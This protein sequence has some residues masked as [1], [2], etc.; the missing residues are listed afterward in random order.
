M[1]FLFVVS[2]FYA[3]HNVNAAITVLESNEQRLSFLFESGHNSISTHKNGNEMFSYISFQESNAEITDSNGIILPVL[4]LHFGVPQQG[5]ATVQFISQTTRRIHLHAPLPV[6]KEN[7]DHYRHITPHS[8]NPWIST[9]EYKH[10]STMRTGHLYL[11]PF[12]YNPS[13]RTITVLLK[14]TCTITFPQ[15]KIKVTSSEQYRGDFAAMLKDMVL[16]YKVAKRWQKPGRPTSGRYKTASI[17]P[18]NEKMLQFTI[19]DGNEGINEATTNENGIIK[20]TPET[21]TSFFGS[22]IL[23]N[24]ISL[25]GSQREELSD[26]VPSVSTIPDGACE[27]PLLRIDRNSNGIFDT[28]D[29]ILAYVTGISDWYYDTV[30][31]DFAFRLN[32]IENNRTYWLRSKG[33]LKT[34]P[35]FHC[36]GIPVDTITVF[37]NR[38]R[39]KKSVELKHE[40][41][42][43][44]KEWRWILL[45]DK[46]HA[47]NLMLELPDVHKG[48]HGFLQVN[49]GTI[50]PSCYTIT[51]GNTVLSDSGSWKVVNNWDNTKATISLCKLS[52]LEITHLDIRYRQSLDMHGKKMMRMYS[53][54]EPKSNIVMYRLKNLPSEKTY[55]FRI[56]S[57]ESRIQIIDIVSGEGTF[58]WV[59]T[60][61]IGMQYI[62]S[63][64]SGLLTINDMKGYYP[65]SP[66]PYVITDLRNTGNKSD[67]LIITDITLKAE[68]VRLAKHK[69]SI[70]TFL[71]PNVVVTDDIYREFSGGNHDPGAIRN[72]L[73]FTKNF[74]T[75]VYTGGTAGP[76][77]V[78]LSGN[79]HYDYKGYSSQEPVIIPTAQIN[80][81]G[82]R[83]CV[84][85]FFSCVTSGECISHS[86]AAPDLF[87][88]RFPVTTVTEAATVIDK[89]VETEGL[90]ADRGPWRNSILLVSDDDMQGNKYD[91]ITHYKGNEDI[92]TSIMQTR[93]YSDIRKVYLFEYPQNELFIKPE[94]S[95]AL[96]NEIN[97]GVSCVNFFGHG[98]EM[99]WADEGILNTSTVSNLTNTKRY[100]VITSFS[101]N[102]GHFDIPGTPCLAGTLLKTSRAGAIAG[103]ASS[104]T[105]SAGQNTSMGKTFYKHLFNTDTYRTLG[106]AYCLTKATD[107]LKR[108]VFLG[109]PSIRFLPP[110]DSIAI[111]ITSEEGIPLGTDTLKAFQQ[112]VVSG[113]IMRNMVVNSS[114]GT[115]DEPAYIQ[116]GL[117]NPQRDSVKRKDGCTFTDPNY[118]NPIYTMPGTPVFIGKTSVTHGEFKQ[119]IFI[120]KNI[121]YRK[122]GVTIRGY[123]WSGSDVATGCKGNLIF[124]GSLQISDP[125]TEG[126][127]IT[128]RPVYTNDSMWNTKVGFTDKISSTLPLECEIIISDDHGID[129]TGIGP[130]EGLSLEIDN[131]IPRQNINHKFI[132]DEGDYA[133]G[134]A[135]VVF[136]KEDLRPGNYT[137]TVRAQDLLG[138]VS[139]RTVALEILSDND[140]KLGHVFNYPNPARM[141][142]KTRFYFYHSNTSEN[143]YSGV[144]ATIK[145]F[146]L[147][148]RLIRVFR[149]ARN[150]QVWDLTD[151][152]GHRLSPN[153]YLYRITVE[154]TN[155]G[156]SNK[157]KI[158]KSS[159][160]K[161][162][163]HPP[164]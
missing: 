133:Q 58:S 122:P 131:A 134:N 42:F 84:D 115:Q 81:G 6:D 120:P 79:G 157:N 65:S 28:D 109:D 95:R 153:I 152:R 73:F 5:T 60:A 7:I 86:T 8:N 18:A 128:V 111:T 108:Y 123:A 112:V 162:V 14:G 43:G 159:V 82:N 148:G 124:Y 29:R 89:I 145:I 103:I 155:S 3:L 76:D 117:Y 30:M 46:N 142:G 143:W 116:I 87:L 59:D 96:I 34:I 11:K 141:G 106:Q 138:K 80:C 1:C 20:I 132:F 61:G 74:W 39:Y 12:I 71:F 75:P 25:W 44:G 26:T 149:N 77:Y 56:P 130:D 151:Q 144:H 161:L 4:S 19:G 54:Q 156:L 70:G 107:N 31:H 97:R 35:S 69:K 98:N 24:S 137:L 150:G 154:M 33:G 21:V 37:E 52:S 32:R 63:T 57:D 22:T 140:F 41:R 93:P 62:V 66:E 101:C 139:K 49:S 121:T 114:F 94:A 91:N 40:N 38:V 102:V 72:F 36:S 163:I 113:K 55:L 15:A 10:Y 68:A 50:S 48:Y 99:A 136:N 53:S 88:G 100:P 27:I 127:F 147:S 85:D 118:K 160:K 47:F 64:E 129:V 135:H 83:L 51:F 90:E 104:R 158:Q 23:I 16:N 78:I 9:V 110:S 164:G 105:A 13:T 146:T 126:P 45:D 92:E 2:I 17:I 119:K 125:D 67:L